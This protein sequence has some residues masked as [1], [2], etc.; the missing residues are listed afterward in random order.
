M[1]RLALW[2]AA[3]AAVVEL[4]DW[5]IALFRGQDTFRPNVLTVLWVLVV[6]VFAL[7]ERAK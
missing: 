3:F 2:G 1:R 6:G 7:L 4:I 5:T